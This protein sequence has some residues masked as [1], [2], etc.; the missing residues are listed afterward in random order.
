MSC[1]HDVLIGT[2]G[3]GEPLPV[4]DLQGRLCRRGVDYTVEEEE[5]EEELLF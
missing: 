5:E 2:D 1:S 3:P 4:S